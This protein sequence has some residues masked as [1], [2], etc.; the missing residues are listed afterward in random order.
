M[1]RYFFAVVLAAAGCAALAAAPVRSVAAARP[2]P[3]ASPTAAPLPTASPEPPNIAIPH[4]LDK[5][6]AN[7]NDRQAMTDLA[8]QYLAIGHPEAALPITQRL[9]QVGTKTAQVY[10]ID[11]D[12]Q[13]QLGNLQAATYDIEAASN[14][15]PT[16]ISVLSTLADLYIKTGRKADAERVANRAVTFNKDEPQAYT[17]LAA[18]Y[19]A[20]QKWD[21]A[22]AQ[23]EKAYALNTKDVSPL[24]Q[25]AQT[26][27]AQNT[28]PNAL[29][30]ID[31]AIAV[32]P[33]NV[34]V[35]IFRADLFARENDFAKSASAYDDAAA[36]ATTDVV[37]ASV[38][39]RKALMYA[40]VAKNQTL[41]RATFDA[42]IKAYP[43]IGSLHTAYGE[44]YI[45]QR[46]RTHAEQELATAVKMDR[47]DV[48]AIV[49]LAQLKEAEGRTTDAINYI[50]QWAE[51]APSA[52]SYAVLGE[53]YVSTHQY[54]KAKDACTHS[55]QI[56]RD[57]DTLGCI[58]GSDYSMKNFK[59][60]VQ[61]FNILENGARQFMDHNPQLLYMEGDSLA[62]VNQPKPAAATFK[63][64]LKL[65]RPGSKGYKDIQ[66]RVAELSKAPA[67][68]KGK[69]HG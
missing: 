27:V 46:D 66:N 42:A 5:L 9:L 18:V 3:S 23:L 64:L 50:K 44:Y 29:T 20:E 14:L 7:P 62:H 47:G 57:P 33:K 61:L 38:M 40:Q 26:W 69:K 56:Q 37:K 25:E 19:A 32:D 36:A 8:N 28:I 12:A 15:E 67:A 21:D 63:R 34:N 41:A 4:L 45:S 10:F 43:A 2:T 1:K 48:N 30:V 39:S 55:F 16:N 65:M 6:K 35:L 11:G 49:D 59:E 51:V 58:A 13:E 52:R 31:R 22:R 17:T 60:A 53:A 68:P 24:V 54:A